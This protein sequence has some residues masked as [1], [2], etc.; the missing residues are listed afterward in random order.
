VREDYHYWTGKLTDC[1]FQLS[2]AVIAANW[3]VFGKVSEV[4]KND[5]SRISIALVVLGLGISLIGAKM[6]G[7]SLRRRIEYAEANPGQW[8]T[9]FQKT[10]GLNDPWPFTKIMERDGRILREC[11]TW[12]PIAGGLFFLLALVCPF[13]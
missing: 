9:E 2:I 1:S 4:L 11:K 6:M 10:H 3:A 8:R 12:L 5:W 13:G 7:E